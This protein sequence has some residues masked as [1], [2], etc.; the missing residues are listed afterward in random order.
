MTFVSEKKWVFLGNKNSVFESLDLELVI[1]GFSG[2]GGM[3]MNK[4]SVW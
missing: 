3:N 2:S 4:A 1:Y